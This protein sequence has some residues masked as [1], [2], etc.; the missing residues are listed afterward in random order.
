[1]NR[2]YLR[3]L[4]LP[5]IHIY[6]RDDQNGYQDYVDQ[7]NARNNGDWVTLTDKR[8]IENYLHPDAVRDAL[9]I[10][11]A[12]DDDADVPQIAARA[13]HE[14]SE[15]EKS[16]DE[17]T[18]VKRD[19]KTSRAKRRLCNDAT[20]RMSPA[21]FRERDPNGEIEGWFRRMSDMLE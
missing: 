8:E 10:T 7:V 20:A 9:S 14:A 13:T 17:L 4:D 5:E 1:M 19:Q 3:D 15:S 21:N 11:I 18:Q 2:H 12:I 16:W 6:D